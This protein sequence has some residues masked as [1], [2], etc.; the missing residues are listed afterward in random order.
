VLKE[1]KKN[2]K[3]GRK[4]EIN[5]DKQKARSMDRRMDGWM[6]IG[7]KMDRKIRV[8]GR[9]GKWVH[10]YTHVNKNTII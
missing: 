4:E 8:Y 1:E 6:N 3:K 10:K 2:N 9:I 5:I 7:I